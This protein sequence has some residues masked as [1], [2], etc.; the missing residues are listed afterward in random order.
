MDIPQPVE[1]MTARE[2]LLAIQLVNDADDRQVSGYPTHLE[3][4]RAIFRLTEVGLD[5]IAPP[6]F[7]LTDQLA[8]RLAE[9]HGLLARVANGEYVEHREIHEVRT[10]PPDLEAMVERRIGK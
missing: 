7:E 6:N 8:D 10:L 9:A 1:P 3:T 5:R 2:A 4:M